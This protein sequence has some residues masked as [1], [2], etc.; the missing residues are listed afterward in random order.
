MGAGLNGL[1]ELGQGSLW[2]QAKLTIAP[3][4]SLLAGYI[5]NTNIIYNFWSLCQILEHFQANSKR[6]NSGIAFGIYYL[7]R[8]TNILGESLVCE[9]N[10]I[11]TLEGNSIWFEDKWENTAPN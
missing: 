8:R 3:S 5:I 9:V 7:H 4:E 10:R 11:W 1:V 6:N 2:E